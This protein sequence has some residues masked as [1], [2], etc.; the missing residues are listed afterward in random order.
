MT[1][2]PG[3]F[4]DALGGLAAVRFQAFV[5]DLWRARG[6][7]VT[8]EGRAVV[9]A[10]APNR[11]LLPLAAGEHGPVPAA[12]DL[13]V[14]AEPAEPS[15]DR[16]VDR[17]GA[18]RLYELFRFAVDEPDAKRLRR[19]YL[20][21]V[22][23]QTTGGTALAAES[24]ADATAEGS[25]EPE[26]A[27]SSRRPERRTVLAGLGAFLA[28]VG[29]FAA[30]NPFGDDGS[31]SPASTASGPLAG[32][33]APPGLSN[34]GVSDTDRLVD[35]HTG[36]LASTSYT[37]SVTRTEHG[38][39]GDLRS[40][41]GL[42]AELGK[43][44]AFAVDVSTGGPAGR[45]LF[46]ERPAQAQLWSP[47]DRLFRRLTARGETRYG[48]FVV[49]SGVGG[50]FYWA[51]VF[52]FAGRRTSTVDFLQWVLGG[53]DLSIAVDDGSHDPVSVLGSGDRLDAAPGQP[54]A[55]APVVERLQG[56]ITNAGLVRSLRLWLR[57]RRE[58]T[59]RR[60]TWS[61]DYRRLGETAVER[62]A[63]LDRFLIDEVLI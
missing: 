3:W 31:E 55:A 56:T 54:A 35:A 63:W 46:G 45:T 17:I 43:R 20:Q 19:R 1:A 9:V 11:R 5:A 33:P 10:D 28:G 50:A 7:P 12:I 62:P 14:R 8:S 2:A 18:D 23:E 22:A 51:N 32:R 59:A 53:T 41:L 13:V 48:E 36:L 40:T 6:R 24:R 44:R 42:H 34:A 26:P 52:P 47:G 60:V 39:G 49:G 57:E 61:I 25:R 16:N 38:P 30:V 27:G 21:P 4:V 29:F 37:L 58:G 15:A